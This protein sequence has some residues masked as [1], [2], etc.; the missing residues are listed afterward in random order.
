MRIPYAYALL[1]SPDYTY[2]YQPIALWSTVEIGVGLTACSLATLTPL[3]RKLKIFTASTLPTTYPASRGV[4]S[5]FRRRRPRDNLPSADNPKAPARGDS[6]GEAL[7]R[8]PSDDEME[9]YPSHT[10][11]ELRSV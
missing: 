5:L 1:E 2:T 7:E 8:Q 11:R 4:D 6:D 3:F 10:P 9:L